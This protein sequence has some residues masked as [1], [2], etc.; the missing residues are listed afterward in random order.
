M[1]THHLRGL[2]ALAVLLLASPLCA[3]TTTVQQCGAD[4]L[5][6]ATR[7]RFIAADPDLMALRLA[8]SYL[9]TNETGVTGKSFDLLG[10]AGAA[11]IEFDVPIP[12]FDRGL[13]LIYANGGRPPKSIAVNGRSR[14][15]VKDAARMLGEAWARHDLLAEELKTGRNQVV[16]GGGGL[17]VDTFSHTGK[18]WRSFDGGKTFKSDAL[19]PDGQW[20]GQYIVRLRVY[21]HPP[22]GEVTSA[23]IDPAVVPRDPRI[24]PKLT[25][26][27]VTLYADEQLPEGTRIRYSI[28]FGTTPT[29]TG[30]TWSDWAAIR[31]GEP[32]A[33][34]DD[35]YLQWRAQLMSDS[36]ARTPVLRG[37]RLIIDAEVIRPEIGGMRVDVYD[38]PP[39][40]HSSYPFTWEADTPRVR[41]LRE[42][43]QLHDVIGGGDQLSQQTALRDWVSRRWDK[44]WSAGLYKYCP[45]WDALE[46]LEM[47]PKHLSLGMCTHFSCVYV[48]TAASVGFDTR[49]VLVQ[50]HCLTEIWSDQFGKWILQDPGPG[51]G[52]QGYPIGFAYQGDGQWLNA[53]D[54]HNALRDKRPVTAVPGK[55]T[56]SPWTLDDRYM[57]LFARFGIP[58]RNNHLSQPEPAEIE[59]GNMGYR[60]DGYLWWTDSVDD[61]KYPEYSMQ[62]NRVA[63]FYAPLNRVAVDLRQQDRSTLTVGLDTLTPN[64]VRYEAAID[65]KPWAAVESGFPWT[66]HGGSN[67]LR[68]R[69]VNV[70][71][72][73]G[74]ETV[75]GDIGL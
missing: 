21:G 32:V 56:K 54:V 38:N 36:S 63:D 19:G 70:F 30:R 69:T 44:G 61:P 42:K 17:Y 16:I 57:R 4:L 39:I 2:V 62:S 41:H 6:T 3:E 68:L 66:L 13:L 34:P 26:R 52:P 8:R 73:T 27:K 75:V 46:L 7:D 24:R 18:S 64:L 67:R 51:A 12:G 43:Y 50:H 48:Q 33:T 59:Q 72:R 47:A 23:V 53:L 45:P 74:R 55:G 65:G 15:Y 10:A 49:S 20:S 22:C 25:L 9:I 14:P 71:G 28:R 58:L 5:E 40:V 60:W 29:P 11:K 35:R 31:S 37:V 1:N